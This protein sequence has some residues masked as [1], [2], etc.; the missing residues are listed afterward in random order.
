MAFCFWEAYGAKHPIFPKRLNQESR[1]LSLT[2][3]ITFISGANFFS[4]LLFW[5][6]QSYNVY[7]HDPVAVGIRSIPIGFGILGGACIVLWLLSVFKG[8]NREL[9]IVSSVFM[10]AGMI[11]L[12]FRS[13]LQRD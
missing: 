8:H 5:P 7:G 9:L 4:V 12:R 10:T 2:L 6:T 11:T 13:C 3:L 1:T